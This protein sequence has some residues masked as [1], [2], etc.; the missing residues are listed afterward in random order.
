MNKYVLYSA[1]LSLVFSFGNAYAQTESKKQVNPTVN[2][3]VMSIVQKELAEDPYFGPYEAKLMYRQLLQNQHDQKIKKEEKLNEFASTLN[4]S[5]E[6]K[7]RLSENYS[8]TKPINYQ[9][10]AKD[11]QQV[12]EDI[13]TDP[14]K[15]MTN[16][17]VSAKINDEFMPVEVMSD[18]SDSQDLPDVTLQPLEQEQSDMTTRSSGLLPIRSVRSINKEP[19]KKPE[20]R[21]GVK[22]YRLNPDNFK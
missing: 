17:M 15:A 1:V 14:T 16:L 13:A 21:L 18:M 6:R 3:D 22:A 20:K 19:E 11:I 2:K 10:T 5:E 4:Y 12:G 7:Q 9:I 8:K